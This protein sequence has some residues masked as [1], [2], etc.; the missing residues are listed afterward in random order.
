MRAKWAAIFKMAI[1]FP[2]SMIFHRHEGTSS[3]YVRDETR[4]V[5]VKPFKCL[6]LLFRST[7]KRESFKRISTW[8]L[9]GPAEEII[10]RESLTA[11]GENYVVCA[12]FMYFSPNVSSWSLKTKEN[13]AEKKGNGEIRHFK[14]MFYM[15]IFISLLSFFPFTA[16]RCSS[17][18]IFLSFLLVFADLARVAL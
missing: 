5:V 16:F 4:S 11:P 8:Q 17:L 13:E 7:L 3:C 14:M 15:K 1:F 2:S 12:F 18:R 9:N 6:F 10:Q